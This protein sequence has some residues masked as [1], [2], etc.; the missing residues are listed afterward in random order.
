MFGYIVV[1]KP[2]LKVREY[3]QYRASYCGLCRS[4]KK[5]HGWAGQLTLS[6]DM[7]FLALLLTGLYEPETLTGS[8]RCIAHPVHPHHYRQNEYFDYA[9]D[10]NVLLTYYKCM[11]DWKD[12]RKWSARAFAAILKPGLRRVRKE[13][14]RKAETT[15]RLLET[16]GELEQEKSRDIDRTAGCFGEIMAE[17]FVYREDEWKEPLWRM[18]FYFGKFIYLMDA[19]EDIEEDLKRGRYN[20]LAGLYEKESFEEECQQILKMMMSETSRVFERLPVVQ[21]AQILRNILYA[22]VW[23]RY[24]QIRCRRKETDTES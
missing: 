2:E 14:G 3:E 21:D 24:G 4:L 10:M 12:D 15:R 5:R 18:G 17:L 19:Y 16:L 9:A 8:R 1:H 7:T 22:G 20:P 6:F 11:D 13:Y 23:T